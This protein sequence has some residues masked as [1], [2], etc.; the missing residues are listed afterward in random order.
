MTSIPISADLKSFADRF[1]AKVR[2]AQEPGA[3][4]PWLGSTRHGYGNIG[5][6][7][8]VDGSRRVVSAHRVAWELT[9]GPIPDGLW[10]LHRCD[11]P[12]CVR[13]THLFLGTP[14]DNVDDMLAKGRHRALAGE[15]H[16]SAKLTTSQVN[17]IRARYSREKANGKELAAEFGVS[18]VMIYRIV[19]QKSW[20]VAA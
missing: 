19:N 14:Q 8:R 17:E 15:Q 6:G 20:K 11:N 2:H 18:N 5:V 12:S 10:V 3:C 9:H 4:W 7:S 16:K 13:P 1:W